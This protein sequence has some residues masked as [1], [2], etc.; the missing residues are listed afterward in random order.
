MIISR[1]R[2]RERQGK[3]A[4]DLLFLIGIL[5]L[6]IP[7]SVVLAHGGGQL[8]VGPVATGPYQV[9]VWTD[10]PTPR[11]DR[12]LHITVAVADGVSNEP[13]L[14]TAVT[15][16]IYPGGSQ[17]AVATL[18]ATA[19]A[20]TNRLFYEADLRLAHEGDY[21]FD[22]S[23]TGPAGSGQV[24]FPLTLEPALPLTWLYLLLAAGTLFWG[25]Y[26][27]QKRPLAG[28]LTTLSR[29]PARPRR[30]RVD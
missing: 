28:S 16:T 27:W 12:D 23:V 19:E 30:P 5:Y 22:I 4:P 9:S 1:P 21:Q 13:V 24:D 8:Q 17:T 2:R 14:N 6:F 11:V 10:P 15:I 29:R 7:I 20:A 3:T 26:W 25:Y 18:P